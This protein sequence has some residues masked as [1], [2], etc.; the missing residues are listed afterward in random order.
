LDPSEDSDS[1]EAK[2]NRKQGRS[3]KGLH[4]VA[5][6]FQMHQDV[7]DEAVAK[8]KVYLFALLDLEQISHS[9]H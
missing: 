8:E 7:L 3:G 4:D 9:S 1:D 5:G 2:A 6:M